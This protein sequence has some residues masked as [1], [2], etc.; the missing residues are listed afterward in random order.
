MSKKGLPNIK[1]QPHESI[2]LLNFINKYMNIQ[3][4]ELL[5]D[6]FLNDNKDTGTLMPQ[7]I[8]N[9]SMFS[10]KDGGDH[11]FEKIHLGLAQLQK[12][13][14][15]SAAK[16]KIIVVAFTGHGFITYPGK[17]SCIYFPSTSEDD[18]EEMNLR[19]INIEDF[20]RRCASLP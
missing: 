16:W 11:A 5:C 10:Q 14:K 8:P 7:D 4:G 3:Q 18:P 15:N 13:A 20:A 2:R 6:Q 19:Y 12:S 1:S 17:E 9:Y